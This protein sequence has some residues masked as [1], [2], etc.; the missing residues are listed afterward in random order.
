MSQLSENA[1]VNL[2]ASQAVELLRVLELQAFWENLKENTPTKD[3]PTGQ[4]KD[5][6]KA[7]EA[8]RSRLAAYTTKYRSFPLPELSQNSPKWVSQWFRVVR[9]VVRAAV[10]GPNVELPTHLVTKAH[11]LGLRVAERLKRTPLANASSPATLPAAVE[12]LEAL[13][14]WSE[15]TNAPAPTEAQSQ[16]A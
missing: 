9:A 8:Y 1:V 6:Q 14:A 2:E 5:R 4:L 7:Y 12:Q 10:D 11:R 16:A 15:A 3:V 13:I